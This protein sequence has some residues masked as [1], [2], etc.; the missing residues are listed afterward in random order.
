VYHLSNISRGGHSDGNNDLMQFTSI[1]S[2]VDDIY[3]H[4]APSNTISLDDLVLTSPSRFNLSKD[5]LIRQPFGGLFL[6]VQT[7]QLPGNGMFDIGTPTSVNHEYQ[8]EYTEFQV[9]SPVPIIGLGRKLPKSD[10]YLP[11]WRIS[12]VGLADNRIYDVKCKKD[13]SVAA[14]KVRDDWAVLLSMQLAR[15]SC[16]NS[17]SQP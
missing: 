3:V 2:K 6:D 14:L 5:L 13:W 12:I 9:Q 10:T 17:T 1:V 11:S 8:I 7:W 15:N 4:F 16:L